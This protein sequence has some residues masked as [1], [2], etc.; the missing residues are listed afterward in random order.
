M[1]K[2]PFTPAVNPAA[3]FINVPEETPDPAP[4]AEASAPISKQEIPEGFKI[5]YRYAEKRSRHVQILLR[6]SL[7][8]KIKKTAMTEGRSVNDVI[9]EMLEKAAER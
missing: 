7:Y 5:D 4:K 8:D 2:K 9:H 1:P 3:L 6:P